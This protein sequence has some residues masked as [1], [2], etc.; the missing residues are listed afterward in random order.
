MNT[1]WK[2]LDD[3]TIHYEGFAPADQQLLCDTCGQ[4]ISYPFYSIALF[5]NSIDFCTDCFHKPLKFQVARNR[6]HILRATCLLCERE[7]RSTSHKARIETVHRSASFY[8]CRACHDTDPNRLKEHCDVVVGPRAGIFQR[9]RS[10]LV[11]QIHAVERFV[12]QHLEAEITETRARQW[13]VLLENLVKI[14]RHFGSIK[15]WCIFSDEFPVYHFGVVYLLYDASVETNGRIA[16]LFSSASCHTFVGMAFLNY[17]DYLKYMANFKPRL[18]TEA[19]YDQ[20][21]Q[22]ITKR[23]YI[24]MIKKHLGYIKHKLT[25]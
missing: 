1:L 5:N 13:L 19:L 25:Q 22:Y 18:T 20:I 12:P 16:V 14:P 15:Q 10:N 21:E 17:N 2:I 4:A 8:L 23:R 11:V 9:T 3:L 24:K 6:R 7:I